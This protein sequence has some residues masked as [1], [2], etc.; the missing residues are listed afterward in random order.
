MINTLWTYRLQQPLK[1]HEPEK[2][3]LRK[4]LNINKFLFVLTSFRGL[5]IFFFGASSALLIQLQGGSFDDKYLKAD[6]S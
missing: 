6:E 5:L 2:I 3:R 4:K 1:N